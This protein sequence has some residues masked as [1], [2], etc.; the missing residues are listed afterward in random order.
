MISNHVEAITAAERLQQIVATT[1]P[2]EM[3]AEDGSIELIYMSL[4]FPTS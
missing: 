3:Q 1:W 4:L 2:S